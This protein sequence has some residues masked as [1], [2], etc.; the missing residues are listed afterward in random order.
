MSE[1]CCESMQ[2]A[3]EDWGGVWWDGGEWHIEQ[4]FGGEVKVADITACP[5]C[6]KALKNKGVDWSSVPEVIQPDE[7]KIFKNKIITGEIDFDW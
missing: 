4:D 1:Y 5:W 2:R 6:K 3:V 7:L